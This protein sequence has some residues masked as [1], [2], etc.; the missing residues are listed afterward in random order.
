MNK[1]LL[2][3]ILFLVFFVAAMWLMVFNF[4]MVPAHS[5]DPFGSQTATIE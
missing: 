2:L 4:S 1:S 5:R 3:L